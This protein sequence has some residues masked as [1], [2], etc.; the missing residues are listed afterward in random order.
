MEKGF[1]GLSY[2]TPASQWAEALPL[3]NAKLGGMIY[4]SIHDE[5]IQI[6]EE[7]V[8][9]GYPRDRDNPEA[10][11]YLAKIRDSIFTGNYDKA[12][13]QAEHMLGV[14]VELES[15][16]PVCDV[17]IRF[18]QHGIFKEYQ[19]GLDITKALYSQRYIRQADRLERSPETTVEA[20]C[21]APANLLAYRFQ[22]EYEKKVKFTVTMR[23]EAPVEVVAKGKTLLLTGQTNEK[24]IRFACKLSLETDGD[25]AASGDKLEVTGA[26]WAELRMTAASD[27]RGEDPV[28]TCN[29]TLEQVKGVSYE[30]LK[31]AHIADYQSL[32]GRHGLKLGCKSFKGT[33]DQLLEEAA[34]SDEARDQLLELWYNYLRYLLICSTRPGSLPSNLQ[35]IWNDN[36]KAP[37]NSDY[38]P[39]VNLQINYWPVEAANL[40][41]CALP[42]ADWLKKAAENGKK[43]AWEHYR[44]GG[45]ALHH[46]SDVFATTA[47]VDG[48]W[49]IWPFGGAWLCRNLYEHHLYNP[50]DM[51][52]LKKTL[53]PLLEG[54][55]RFMLDF[56]VECPQGIPGEG[57]LVTC[58]SHSPENRFRAP[59][60]EVSW[61]TYGATM[62]IEIIRD[63]FEMYA[64]CCDKTG[65]KGIYREETEKARDRL[66]PIKVSPKTG[67]I[68]EWI[69]D[70]EEVEVGHRHVSHLYA[71]HPGGQINKDTPELLEAAEKVLERRL[72][73]HYHGQG[74]SCGWIANHFAR[75]GKGNRSLDMLDMIVSAMLLP[76]LMVDAHGH[77]QVGDAQASASAIQE[78]LA[79]SHDGEIALLPAL[80]ER[81]KKG[82]VYGLRLRGG[83]CL[84][85]EWSG[86][87]LVKAVLSAAS[88]VPVTVR[89]GE[90][91]FPL[92][93]QNGNRYD[94]LENVK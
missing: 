94:L 76:N 23:R 19:R 12:M 38:H 59:N 51:D 41:E 79:Q 55:V 52:F 54:S 3:G 80:P 22:S 33:T 2:H 17:L 56:L 67:C 39:N 25:V 70:Y 90:K 9:A 14:P 61:L 71:L 82:S 31:Q 75:L 87:K 7:T 1:Y 62:D 92:A 72:A 16:Q 21:S 50:A 78:M 63:L 13:E 5:I 86:G 27:F 44:A 74:W 43:T 20:F 93:L 77:P 47:P 84:D 15:Y 6:N 65:V 64:D 34:R 73:N 69:D 40:P 88:D 91:R 29:G 24:G 57:Y 37:W 60:G 46:A 81:W 4:G 85:I 89:I 35:G 49:G 30:E 45:W 36:M 48:P 53:F 66:P 11:G 32:Y 18:H 58:P 42:L 8:W 26:S 10:Y 83:H 68:Q 28:R